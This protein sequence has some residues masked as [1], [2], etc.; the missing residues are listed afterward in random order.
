MSTNLAKIM[1]IIRGYT[2]RHKDK[3]IKEISSGF[4]VITVPY[5]SD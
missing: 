1:C 3:D 2:K 4:S 5:S